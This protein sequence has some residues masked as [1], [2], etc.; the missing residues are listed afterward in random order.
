MAEH[1]RVL[2]TCF[3]VIWRATLRRGRIRRWRR[4]GHRRK[5]NGRDRSAPLQH[6]LVAAESR[7]G[8]IAARI[9]GPLEQLPARDRA[10]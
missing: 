8:A 7:F 5:R 4:D 9:F 2:R 6:Y 3:Q 1:A 10:D